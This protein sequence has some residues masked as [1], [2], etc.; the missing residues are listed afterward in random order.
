MFRS[1][2]N[3]S[4]EHAGSPRRD[5]DSCLIHI[6]PTSPESRYNSGVTVVLSTAA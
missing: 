1:F 2:R 6:K 5:R 4:P 3:V